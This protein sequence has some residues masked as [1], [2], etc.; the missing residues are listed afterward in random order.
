MS[1][2]NAETF[3]NALR[4]GETLLISEADGAHDAHRP[5]LALPL[6]TA[7]RSQP[8]VFNQLYLVDQPAV[9]ANG[10]IF[11]V[12]FD[13][14]VRL[15]VG[16]FQLCSFNQDLAN[17]FKSTTFLRCRPAAYTANRTLARDKCFGCPMSVA[18]R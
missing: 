11:D 10:D 6:P 7:C 17:G 8:S 1:T 16:A 18:G 5:V 9:Q 13:E 4:F 3:I 2:P 14:R 12:A 15:D